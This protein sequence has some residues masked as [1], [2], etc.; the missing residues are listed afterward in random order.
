MTRGNRT[1]TDT[2]FCEQS[3]PQNSPD[4]SG[5]SS[6]ETVVGVSA[7]IVREHAANKRSNTTIVVD[8]KPIGQVAELTGQTLVVA[9]QRPCSHVPTLAPRPSFATAPS[10]QSPSARQPSMQRSS[11][12]A[13]IVRRGSGCR[14]SSAPPQDRRSAEEHSVHVTELRFGRRVRHETVVVVQTLSAVG[15]GRRRCKSPRRL[16]AIV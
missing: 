1:Q 7:A 4:A 8:T 14:S 11:A 12:S 15:S 13:Q 6:D 16:A 3:T 9:V 5:P 10:G 2:R